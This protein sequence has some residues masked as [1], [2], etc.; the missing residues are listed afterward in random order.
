MN[1]AAA[2]DVLFRKFGSEAV[3]LHLGTERYFSLNDSALRMWELLS[4]GHGPQDVAATVA[5]EYDVDRQTVAA[6]VK[7][8]LAELSSLK[9]ITVDADQ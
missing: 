6:D 1:I 3:L 5:E 8:L 4:S 9:L 2:P 7:A